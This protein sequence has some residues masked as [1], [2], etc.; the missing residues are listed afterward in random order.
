[1]ADATLRANPMF[2]TISCIGIRRPRKSIFKEEVLMLAPSLRSIMMVPAALPRWLPTPAP[3]LL[4]HFVLTVV[5]S[6]AL[7]VPG[8]AVHVF[9]TGQPKMRAQVATH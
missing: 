2:S 1:M 9:A 6:E 5:A 3:A 7:H 8:S 4:L